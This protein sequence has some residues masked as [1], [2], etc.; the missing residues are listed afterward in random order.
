MRYAIAL[1]LAGCGGAQVGQ[2]VPA[3]IQ[4]SKAVAEL[5][6]EH[7]GAELDDLPIV[8]EHEYAPEGKLLLLCEVDLRAK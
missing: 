6:R 7:S 1:L 2:Y 5:V 3:V 8:C 4:V